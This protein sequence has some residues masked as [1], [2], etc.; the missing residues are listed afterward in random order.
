MPVVHL[1][2]CS[3]ASDSRHRCSELSA[4]VPRPSWLHAV[5][6]TDARIT[7]G[8][9]GAAA[10]AVVAAVVAAA[11]AAAIGGFGAKIRACVTGFFRFLN[12]F[13]AAS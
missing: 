8:R 12:G 6:S 5:V 10:A 11:V 1:T 4:L 2:S 13:N 7:R 9:A 3:V